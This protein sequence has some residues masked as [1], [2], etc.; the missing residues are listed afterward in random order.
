MSRTGKAVLWG[1]SL[2]SLAAAALAVIGTQGLFGVAPDGL[3][4]VYLILV[5]IPW[6]FMVSA[7][8]L[9]GV[10][11]VVGQAAI[12]VAP[13]INIWILTRIFRRR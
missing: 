10:P 7:L 11:V 6:S 8:M 9:A 1:Y 3:S 12:F 5:G 13:L 4:A 2:I